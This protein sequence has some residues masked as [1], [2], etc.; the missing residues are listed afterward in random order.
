M[1]EP[2]RPPAGQRPPLLVSRQVAPDHE[3]L[4]EFAKILSQAS[5]PVFICGAAIARGSGWNEAVALAEALGAP[6]WAAPSSERA[7]FPEH[8]PL[9]CGG[10]AFDTG[11]LSD[12]L[13]GHDVALV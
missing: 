6:V 3:R 7:S 13:K 5:S 4:A 8:H 9:Y 1:G 11:P 10:L 2:P 12:R